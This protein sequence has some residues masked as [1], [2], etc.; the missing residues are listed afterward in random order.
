M[1]RGLGIAVR[2]VLL[3]AKGGKTVSEEWAWTR[4]R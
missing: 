4:A 1:G 3:V 2:L